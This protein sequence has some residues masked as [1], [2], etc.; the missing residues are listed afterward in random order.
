[1]HVLVLNAD[2]TPINITTLKRGFGLY[3]KGK[4]DILKEYP[5]PIIGGSSTYKRPSVIIMREYINFP[6]RKVRLNRHNIL[7]R[8]DNKCV[9]CGSKERLTLDHV[10]PKSKGGG[11]TWENLVTCCF[12]CNFKKDNKTY[13]EVGFTMSHKPFRPTFTYFLQKA[14]KTRDEWKEYFKL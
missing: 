7:K 12:S 2:G 5:Q 4:V 3:Y 10:I 14:Y 9:Y 11:N 13:K 1:M 6:F 8:D